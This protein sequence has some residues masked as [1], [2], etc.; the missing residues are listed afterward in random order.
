V[1]IPAGMDEELVCAEGALVL[2]RVLAEIERRG[3]RYREVF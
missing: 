1:K 2:Q 3:G